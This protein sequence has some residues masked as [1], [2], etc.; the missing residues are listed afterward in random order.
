MALAI[1]VA[2]PY[3]NGTKSSTEVWMEQEFVFVRA[4]VSNQTTV[5]WAVVISG[6]DTAFR[7]ARTAAV[8]A[9]GTA[10]GLTIASNEVVTG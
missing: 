1:A 4:G 9:A 8:Q 5:R 7:A 2:G 6:N 3:Q 10:L